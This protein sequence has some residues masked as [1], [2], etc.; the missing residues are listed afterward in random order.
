MHV[1]AHR[2]AFQLGGLK[3]VFQ[4][5]CH[6]VITDQQ[7]AKGHCKGIK[8]RKKQNKKTPN[9]YLSPSLIP[10]PYLI[11]NTEIMIYPSIVVPFE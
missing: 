4:R 8:R 9:L 11:T 7:I 2:A 6:E 5:S 10:L 1:L 3:E